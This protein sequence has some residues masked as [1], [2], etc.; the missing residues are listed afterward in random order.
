[1]ITGRQRH[2]R[3]TLRRIYAFRRHLIN[4][5]SCLSS[6][7]VSFPFLLTP[8]LTLGYMETWMT[9][10]CG[11][12]AREGKSLGYSGLTRRRAGYADFSRSLHQHWGMA[13]MQSKL[14]QPYGFQYITVSNRVGQ[15][16]HDVV[17]STSREIKTPIAQEI[18]IRLVV[19]MSVYYLWQAVLKSQTIKVCVLK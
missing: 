8:L 11:S 14:P 15:S 12:A 17:W 5:T 13:L 19:H 4:G 3:A 1:M 10:Q 16:E 7:L 9:S 18:C 2:S 6:C